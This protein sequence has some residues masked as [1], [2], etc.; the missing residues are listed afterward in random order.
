MFTDKSYKIIK[1][2]DFG[3]AMEFHDEVS[4]KKKVGTPFYVAPEIL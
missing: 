1:I 4:Y 3:L 2:I